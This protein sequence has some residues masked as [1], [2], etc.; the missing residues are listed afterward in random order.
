MQFFCTPNIGVC[1]ATRLCIVSAQNTPH[2]ATAHNMIWCK[3]KCSTWN[4][5]KNDRSW[6]VLL[7]C[8]YVC[9]QSNIQHL[10]ESTQFR[11][12]SYFSRSGEVKHHSLPF[13]LGRYWPTIIKIAWCL[14]TSMCLNILHA[15]YL[16][17]TR[18][19]RILC[20]DVW[21][22]PAVKFPCCQLI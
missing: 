9:W 15:G 17:L 5:K 4:H 21:M 16:H 14:H 7:W 8:W 6:N 13:F 3:R 12:F 11:D 19:P 1:R 20:F 2:P 10:I 22:L 18:Q